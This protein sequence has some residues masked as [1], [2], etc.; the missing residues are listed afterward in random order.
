[1]TLNIE[2]QEKNWIKLYGN[3]GEFSNFN[4]SYTIRFFS[5]YANNK[6]KNSGP[7]ELLSELKPMRERIASNEIRDISSLLQRDLNDSRVANELIPYLVEGNKRNISFFPSILAALIPKSFLESNNNSV[8]PKSNENESE[9]NV[10]SIDYEQMWRL[11][12]FLDDKGE[13]TPLGMLKIDPHETEIV[14]LDGQHRANAFRVLCGALDS[15]N[16]FYEVFYEDIETLDN[17]PSD[18]PVTLIWFESEQVQIE[19]TMISRKLFV[20]VN[21]N[22]RSVSKSRQILLDDYE[23]SSVLTR[24]FYTS[25]ASKYQFSEEN[26]SLLHTGFDID[27]DLRNSTPHIFTITLPQIIHEVFEWTLFGRNI[28]LNLDR[29]QVRRSPSSFTDTSKCAKMLPGLKSKISIISDDDSVYQKKFEKLPDEEDY[30]EF[31]DILFEPMYNILNEHPLIST[32]LEACQTFFDSLDDEALS[33]KTQIWERVFLG[34]EGLYYS[35][36]NIPEKKA[37]NSIKIT[38]VLNTINEIEKSF[39]KERSSKLENIEIKR[40]DESLKSIRTKAFQVGY[41]AAFFDYL[42]DHYSEVNSDNIKECSEYFITS[43][44]EL[45]EE[46]WVNIF[47]RLRSELIQGTNPKKWPA[48]HKIILRIIQKEGEYFNKTENRK[49]SPEVKVFSNLIDKKF[50]GWSEANGYIKNDV[51]YDEVESLIETW[52]DEASNEVKSIFDD[53][54]IEINNNFAWDEIAN[55]H[56]KNNTITEHKHAE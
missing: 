2:S 16:S 1:M 25:I 37:A 40:I 53:C 33:D 34:G 24:Y 51:K 11:D 10:S 30:Q 39:S 5:T 43:I 46:N 13:L 27:S 14:V 55:R 47:T 20:D 50:E 52:S 17:Y 35:I 9:N 22:A 19:P 23:P 48:Y 41:Y 3:Y 36:R 29:Y 54:G 18:L 32:H 21:N 6:E 31:S 42:F 28:D 4:S 26:I 45:N 38:K 12:R 44:C 49:Y 56:I 15:G 8:Y 7:S